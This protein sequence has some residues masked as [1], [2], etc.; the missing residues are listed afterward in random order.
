MTTRLAAAR[1]LLAAYL[2]IL[3]GSLGR[4]AVQ[5]LYFGLLVNSLSLAEYGV[6]AACVSASI[7]LASGGSFGFVAPLFR[8]AT[9]QQK[10]LGFYLT[11]L[12]AYVLATIPVVL[13][14]ALAMHAAFFGR[15]IALLPFLTIVLSEA[16][17]TR[18]VDAIY[19]LFL[20]LGR[21]ATSTL[22][23]VV[24]PVARTCAAAAAWLL[25]RHDLESFTWLYLAGNLGAMAA[26]ALLS[27]RGPVRW[28]SRVLWGGL[29]QSLSYEAGNLAQALQTELD[30]ILFIALTNQEFA[31]IYALSMRIIDLVTVPVRG[32]FP[33]VVRKLIRLP[34][35]LQ[36]RRLRVGLEAGIAAGGLGLYAAVLTV[37][38]LRPNILGRNVAAAHEWFSSFALL[39]AT[40]MLII[41]HGV[42]FFAANR[43]SVAALVA[44]SVLAAQMAGLYVIAAT[45][46]DRAAWPHAIDS[47]SLCL[48]LGSLCSTICFLRSKAPSLAPA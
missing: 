23:V 14:L 4:L 27:P 42:L 28:R 24:T 6:F 25:G 11:A 17:C 8:A 10:R 15:Y 16:L 18:Y 32:V 44:A 36:D 47:L 2:K 7:I 1:G 37:L 31:G 26:A 9:V 40:K 30:K 41:Y 12:H 33:L 20:G 3:T 48:Y 45:I 43:L 19:Q 38:S 5:A 46:A 22:L 34:Q 39:P 29:R 35:G 21:F 13:L